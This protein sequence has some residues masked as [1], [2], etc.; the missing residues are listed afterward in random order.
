MPSLP[1]QFNRRPLRVAFTLVEMLVVISIIG[2]LVALLLP[3]L[4]LAR[5]AARNSACQNNL[6]QFGQ[7]LQGHAAL[8]HEQ[9][10][11]GA[12]DWALDGAVTEIGWVADLV[13]V[14]T[15]VG[16]MLC[17]SN[18][19]RVAQTYADLLAGSLGASTCIDRAGSPA[20]QG[21]LGLEYNACRAILEGRPNHLGN[22]IESSGYGPNRAAHV[23]K[24]I[25]AESFN[26]NYTASWFLVRGDVNINA[27]T[28]NLKS[29]TSCT[30]AIAAS[31]LQRAYT[32][33]P[34]RLSFL[35]TS[36]VASS[37]VPLLADG[38]VTG[39]TL[40]YD[41]GTESAGTLL[42]RSMTSGPVLKSNFNT[43]NP[44][45]SQ[46]NGAS[47]WWKVWNQDVLQDYRGFGVV[48]RGALNV[49]FADG[50][51]R[52][53]Q[54]QNNDGLLNNGFGASGGFA[55]NVNE[56]PEGDLFSLYSLDAKRN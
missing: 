56:F 43:P 47:G 9:L 37:F 22:A 46:R 48:H 38:G 28:G 23:A 45:A 27:T 21:A 49:L 52:P 12:F 7:G 14:G 19:A 20:K 8:H 36:A 3:A 1:M 42:V 32:K 2:I 35:D 54:D 5:E 44:S 41:I 40:A 31:A 15:P 6:R 18:N 55:D 17:P 10:C 34:L 39:D 25:F 24:S 11:S 16:K 51:V 30:P 4:N 26:T 29:S 53:L 33:G 13:K 50:S